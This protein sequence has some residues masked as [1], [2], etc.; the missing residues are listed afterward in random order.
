MRHDAFFYGD[1]E[2]YV[3]GVA[4]FLGPAL[5]DGTPA[6]VAVPGARLP[7]LRDRFAAADGAVRYLDM[8]RVGR[9]PA[10]IIPTIRDALDSRPGALLRF[11][12]EPIWAQR[13]DEEIVEATRNEAL[14]NRAFAHSPIEMLCPY[15]ANA[16]HPDVIADAERTHPHVAHSGGRNASDAHIGSRLPERCLATLP[17]P[18]PEVD[19]LRFGRTE[20][21]SVRAFVAERAGAAGLA[22][23]RA[24]DA[25]LAANELAANSVRHGGGSGTLRA[26][27]AGARLAVEVQDAGHIMDPLVGRVRPAR[28]ASSSRGLWL[29]QQVSDL[30]QIRTGPDGTSVRAHFDRDGDQA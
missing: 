14:L 18:P 7:L 29:V 20:L 13:S 25:V 12:G 17:P 27:A 26:W 10:R 5:A 21:A 9:N 3:N 16:L 28:G 22:R 8:C 30:V 6:L 23:A 19:L 24:D 11:V 2:Q 1:D 4:G 15:D